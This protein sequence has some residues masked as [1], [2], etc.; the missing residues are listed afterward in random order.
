MG[1]LDDIAGI[2]SLQLSRKADPRIEPY[3]EKYR[4][5]AD[6]FRLRDSHTQH[7]IRNCI[8]GPE[9]LFY[10]QIY[11]SAAY[12]LQQMNLPEDLCSF[13]EKDT[14]PLAGAF[15]SAAFNLSEQS[16]LFLHTQIPLEGIGIYLPKAKSIINHSSIIS[17]GYAASGRIHNYG[18]IEMLGWSCHDATLLNFG[19]VETM[20][21]R[22]KNSRIINYNNVEH[23]EADEN[24]LLMNYGKTSHLKGHKSTTIVN[25]GSTGHFEPLRED[26]I[27]INYGDMK[28]GEE[29][30]DPF[31]HSKRLFYN[32]I[33]SDPVFYPTY[34]I[35]TFDAVSL[36]GSLADQALAPINRLFKETP[37]EEILDAI[38][39]YFGTLDG[40]II[41]KKILRRIK[42]PRLMKL[43]S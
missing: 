27:Q 19:T 22:C 38:T 24:S 39:N 23:M 8:V 31:K 4:H 1:L 17:A 21:L 15:L 34:G 40:G 33:D 7:F 26:S 28:L 12:L 37:K 9:F 32:Y 43:F 35:A 11:H 20:G 29:D 10:E 18:T 36:E 41:A 13:L 16:T 3:K 5:W 25:L 14:S 2:D 42:Y 6:S 30:G